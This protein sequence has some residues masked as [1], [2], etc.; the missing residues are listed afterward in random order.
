MP[1]VRGLLPE[2]DFRDWKAIEAWAQSIAQELAPVP[3]SSGIKAT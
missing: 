3:A 2:G 1:A